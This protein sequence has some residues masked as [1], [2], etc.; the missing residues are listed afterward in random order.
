MQF[1]S[2]THLYWWI[3]VGSKGGA[4]RARIV[5]SLKDYPQNAYQ[6]SQNLG[7]NYRTIIHHLSVLEENYIV[8][9]E[10]PKYGKV[11]FLTDA[12]LSNFGLFDQIVSRVRKK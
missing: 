2:S 1:E 6:L 11:Y 8:K 9:S 7:V 10:G 3:F 4:M 5:M 12:F